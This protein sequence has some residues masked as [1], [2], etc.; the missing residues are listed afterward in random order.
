V[1]IKLL[2]SE[3]CASTLA[4]QVSNSPETCCFSI[5]ICSLGITLIFIFSAQ[6][7]HSKRTTVLTKLVLAKW[8]CPCISWH[9]CRRKMFDGYESP[10][11]VVD[12]FVYVQIEALFLV[13][14]ARVSL[15]FNSGF[16]IRQNQLKC[17]QRDTQLHDQ[18]LEPPYG[19]CTCACC[20]QLYTAGIADGKPL[21]SRSS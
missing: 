11:Y 4:H 18:I 5:A 19:V 17:F 10:R 14:S 16:V 15:H 1:C 21:R 3:T 7:L 6:T 20:S 12:H 9:E 2:V 13:M 8:F